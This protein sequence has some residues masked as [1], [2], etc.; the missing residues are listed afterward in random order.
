MQTNHDFKIEPKKMGKKVAVVLADNVDPDISIELLSV[1][2]EDL[3]IEPIC[4]E[5]NRNLDEGLLMQKDLMEPLIIDA[6]AEIIYPILPLFDS[7]I[8]VLNYQK[9][10]E[11]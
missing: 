5:G 10:Y 3:D 2:Y 4:F 1:V 7:E 11:E 6:C 8:F 9:F